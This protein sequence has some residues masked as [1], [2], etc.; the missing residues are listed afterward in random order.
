M[1]S[2]VMFNLLIAVVIVGTIATFGLAWVN[3]ARIK[4]RDADDA[5]TPVTGGTS[6]SSSRDD[7]KI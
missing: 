2:S 5:A 6:T 1:V 4:N 3:K 7:I